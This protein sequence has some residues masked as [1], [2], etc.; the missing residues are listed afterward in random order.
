[1]WG[2]LLLIVASGRSVLL[3]L[4]DRLPRTF[5]KEACGVLTPNDE[6]A[7]FWNPFTTEVGCRWSGTVHKTMTMAATAEAW[8]KCRAVIWLMS[9]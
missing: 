9:L 2:C 3:K 6:C 4:H 1:M 5:G 8:E 7:V